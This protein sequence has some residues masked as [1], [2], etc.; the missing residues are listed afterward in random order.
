M[1]GGEKVNK[2]IFMMSMTLLA[3][4]ILVAPV[5]AEPLKAEVKNDIPNAEIING[6]FYGVPIQELTQILPSGVIHN[7]VYFPGATIHTKILPRDKFDNP[8]TLDVGDDF[9]GWLANTDYLG[10]WVKMS[11]AGYVGLH[12]AFGFVDYPFELIPEEGVYIMGVYA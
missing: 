1:K 12:L 7:W 6:S 11:K 10:K 8:T 5:M 4:T 2:K 3:L 9:S